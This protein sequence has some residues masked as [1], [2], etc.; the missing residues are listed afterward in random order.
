MPE[1]GSGVSAGLVPLGEWALDLGHH[2]GIVAR[3]ILKKTC[4]EPSLGAVA[5]RLAGHGLSQ[6]RK[7]QARS[8]KDRTDHHHLDTQG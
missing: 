3:L 5:G 2:K 6:G 4:R 8:W 7:E 1:A